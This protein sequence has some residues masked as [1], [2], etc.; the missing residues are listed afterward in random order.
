MVCRDPGCLPVY[1]AIGIGGI[2]RRPMSEDLVY[3][4]IEISGLGGT[5]PERVGSFVLGIPR[6]MIEDLWN[7][8]PSQSPRIEGC[9]TDTGQ[10]VSIRCSEPVCNRSG[11]DRD[12]I[13]SA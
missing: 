2:D 12:R 8:N 10:N 6:K 7:K 11:V 5:L 9:L 13:Y 1:P 4:R 3:R